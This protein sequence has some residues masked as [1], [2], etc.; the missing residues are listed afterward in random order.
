MGP[1]IYLYHLSQK[2][3][4]EPSLLSVAPFGLAVAY[5]ANASARNFNF[6]I[7][8]KTFGVAS[9]VELF[10]QESQVTI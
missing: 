10:D 4:Y 5:Y 9:S 6:L 7:I 8:Y 1:R 3:G 2:T